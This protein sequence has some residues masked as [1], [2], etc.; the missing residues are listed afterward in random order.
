LDGRASLF[1]NG[2]IENREIENWEKKKERVLML[3][4][5]AGDVIGSVHEHSGTKTKNFP[6]FVEASQFTD[7]TV[8]TV[9]VAE[10]LLRGGS[11][12]D[13]YHEYFH[14][15]PEAGYG[16]SFIHW[17]EHRC[18]EPYYSWGNG[19]AMRVSPIGIACNTLEEVL[20]QAR[21][22]AE[23]TH[24]HPE[25]IRGAQ[26]TAAAVFLARSGYT[27]ADIKT[28]IEQE[29]GYCLSERLDDIREHYCFDVSCQGSVPQSIIAFLEAD[30]F[31]DAVRNAISLGGDADTMACIAGGIAEAFFGG[32]PDEIA[33]QTLAVLDE[34]LRNV[35]GEFQERFADRLPKRCP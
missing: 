16:S 28:Y 6:L 30:G 24:N 32:V 33:S 26:A 10:R 5:I 13:W 11:Y 35:V 9:A 14:A 29:F 1:G 27:K 21:A 17:A 4:A 25:G 18:R 34:R 20:A 7:D 22:S 12:V 8:L 31:E 19:A 2:E 23:V 15:Y 3:G